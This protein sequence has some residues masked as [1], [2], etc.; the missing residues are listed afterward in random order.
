MTGILEHTLGVCKSAAVS[1]RF[2]TVALW[3]YASAVLMTE[4]CEACQ[5]SLNYASIQ[6]KHACTIHV[7]YL[8]YLFGTNLVPMLVAHGHSCLLQH[9]CIYVYIYIYVH[10]HLHDSCYRFLTWFLCSWRMS[11]VA[12]VNMCIY[13]RVYICAHNHLH[14]S[15]Y[16]CLTWFLCSWRMSTVAYSNA[17]FFRF[18]R[19]HSITVDVS[20]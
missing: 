16:K 15:C 6:H 20:T 12:Y 13:I 18:A 10:N 8:A 5:E 11:T 14:V 7:T 9:V 2:Q 1:R 19:W 3:T 17:L 4:T